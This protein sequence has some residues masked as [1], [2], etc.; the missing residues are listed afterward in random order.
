VPTNSPTSPWTASDESNPSAPSPPLAPPLAT[1]GVPSTQAV[2]AAVHLAPDPITIRRSH[3]W[4]KEFWSNLFLD[5][6]R[7]TDLCGPVGMRQNN[8]DLLRCAMAI[9]VI[10]SHSYPVIHGKIAGA[11]PLERWGKGNMSFGA[12]AVNVFFILSGFLIAMSWE[13]SATVAMQTLREAAR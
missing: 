6:A 1:E 11:E 4:T 10:F 3:P 8:F 12:L 13:R 5:K 2:S 7:T 9:L